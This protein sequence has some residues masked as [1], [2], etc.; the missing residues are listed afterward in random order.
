MFRIAVEKDTIVA[1]GTYRLPGRAFEL[2]SIPYQHRLAPLLL[3]HLSLPNGRF[4]FYHYPQGVACRA[5]WDGLSIATR[6]SMS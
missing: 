1:R 3:I 5:H 4:L 2:Q 6:H